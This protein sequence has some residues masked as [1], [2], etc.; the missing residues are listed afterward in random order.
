MGTG[1][2]ELSLLNSPHFRGAF[3]PKL[4]RVELVNTG[5][6]QAG[7]TVTVIPSPY[8]SNAQGD[9]NIVCVFPP[10]YGMHQYR[11]RSIINGRLHVVM[12]SE[13]VQH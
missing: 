4:E 10:E 11:I 9:F 6:F 12:E 8:L 5:K 13:I 3:L 2:T 7:Q 1:Q